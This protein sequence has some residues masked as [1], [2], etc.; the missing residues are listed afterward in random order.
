MR[1][2]LRI[3]GM[4]CYF[5]HTPGVMEVT[6]ARLASQALLYVL[7]SQPHTGLYSVVQF[8]SGLGWPTHGATRAD[9][10]PAVATVTSSIVDLQAKNVAIPTIKINTMILTFFIKS[11]GFKG[12]SEIKK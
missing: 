4:V 9:C 6:P 10:S 12:E 7:P 2:F 3:G 5:L 1:A 8:K 11:E